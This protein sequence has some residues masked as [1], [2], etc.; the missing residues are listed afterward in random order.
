[1]NENRD[2][3]DWDDRIENDGCGE[4]TLLPP[5][6]YKFRVAN[7]ERQLSSRTN[8]NMAKLTLEVNYGPELV[9]VYDYLVLTR[10]AEW[11]LSAFFRSIG[12]KKQGESAAMQWNKVRNSIGRAQFSIGAYK[13]KDGTEGTSN[14]VAAYLDCPT[15]QPSTGSVSDDDDSLL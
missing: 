8:A 3:L 7:V 1:M 14:K 6:E 10:K 13:R 5:G 15:S 12:L 4:F 2:F 11:K 9:R